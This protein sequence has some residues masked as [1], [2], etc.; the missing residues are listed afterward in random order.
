MRQQQFWPVDIAEMPA[1]TRTSFTRVDHD[2]PDSAY[3]EIPAVPPLPDLHLTASR[4]DAD[5]RIYYDYLRDG[6]RPVTAEGDVPPGEYRMRRE[7]VGGDDAPADG[8]AYVEGGERQNEEYHH[9]SPSR[10]PAPMGE[11][12]AQLVSSNG[13]AQDGG[14]G[15]HSSRSNSPQEPPAQVSLTFLLV[16]GRRRVMTFDSQ[17]TV[18]RVKELVWNTWPNGEFRVLL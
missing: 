11:S 5:R 3:D 10:S 4:F 1:S 8:E 6:E 7:I 15:S 13:Q 14:R 18:G 9:H 17:T 16:T 12:A 2:R